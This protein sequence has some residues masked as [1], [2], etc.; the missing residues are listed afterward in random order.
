MALGPSLSATA[1]SKAVSARGESQFLGA[2]FD[3]AQLCGSVHLH[4]DSP[5]WGLRVLT[6]RII[7]AREDR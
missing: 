4:G 3:A 6:S 1:L 7:P 5:D 2:H